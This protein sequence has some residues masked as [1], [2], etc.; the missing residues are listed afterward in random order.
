MGANSGRFSVRWR[1]DVVPVNLVNLERV[2]VSYGADPLLDRVSL[3]VAAGDRV[4][5]V[6]RNGSGKT[7]LL[8]VLTGAAAPDRGR[9]TLSSRPRIGYLRQDDDLD[10]QSTVRA[11]VLGGR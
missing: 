2:S 5:V 8:R 7:T 6:G 10:P 11:N 1:I 4:G 9:V 3:G